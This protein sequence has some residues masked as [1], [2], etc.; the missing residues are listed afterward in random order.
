MPAFTAPTDAVYVGGRGLKRFFWNQTNDVHNLE[1]VV[2][3]TTIE[4][5]FDPQGPR[6]L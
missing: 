6:N 5:W 3:P 4:N 2:E 1:G